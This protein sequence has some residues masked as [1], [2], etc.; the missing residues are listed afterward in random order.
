MFNGILALD[1]FLPDDDFDDSDFTISLPLTRLLLMLILLFELFD[2]K[3]PSA[4]TVE[5]EEVEEGNI[6][7]IALEE[8]EADG[9]PDTEVEVEVRIGKP[10]G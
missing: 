6:Q 3:I 8:A 7:G 2:N 4:T 9:F 5:I 10:L 1:R